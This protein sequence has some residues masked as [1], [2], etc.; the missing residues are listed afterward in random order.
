MVRKNSFVED[1]R[2]E[3]ASPKIKLGWMNSQMKKGRFTEE[4]RLGV[5][6]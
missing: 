1:S 2:N 5:I 6:K 3:T 4:G